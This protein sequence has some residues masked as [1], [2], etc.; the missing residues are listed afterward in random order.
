M[1]DPSNISVEELK[2]ALNRW[3]VPPQQ[4][5][6]CFEKADLVKLY[7]QNKELAEA[8]QAQRAKAANATSTSSS[9]ST[10]SVPSLPTMPNIG[11]SNLAFGGLLLLFTLQYLGIIGD[12]GMG[13][14][15][16]GGGD[17]EVSF[18]LADDSYALG[19]V[20]EVATLSEFNGALQLHKDG[21]GL[22]I[23]V[24]FFSHSCGPCKMIAPTFRKYAKEFKGRAVFLKVDVN[25]NRQT[26]AQ[27]QIR[28]MPT[29]QFYV[30]GKKVAEFSGADSR[31]LYSVTSD[32]AAKAEKKGTYV[33]KHVTEESLLAF[34]QA[35]D[36]SKVKDVPKVASK[37]GTKTAK[38]IRLLKKKYSAVPTLS[39]VQKESNEDDKDDKDD[40]NTQSTSTK[41]KKKKTANKK[42]QKNAKTSHSSSSLQSA[43]LEE[44]RQAIREKE[45]SEGEA[46]DDALDNA[47]LL[48]LSS[49]SNTLATK[50]N[51]AKVVVVGG[52]PAG[53]TAAIYSARAGLSPIVI[54]PSFGGQLLGK[55]V[56]VEN[57]PGVIGESAT[58]RGI[59]T[60]MRKQALSFDTIMVDDVAVT[61]DTSSTP[62]SIQVNGTSKRI[63]T[64]AII[65]ATGAD[66]RWLGVPGEYKYRGKGISSCA[67]CDGFLYRGTDVIVVG[68]GDTAMEDALVLARTSKTV[69]L[70]HRRGTFRASHVLQERVLNHKNI[71]IMWNTVVEQF[72]GNKK[73]GDVTHVD[74]K[75]TRPSD[76]QVSTRTLPI[77]A[78]FI[79][80]GHDPNT[81]FL[82]QT[83]GL[84]IDAHG[85]IV[86]AN[87]ESTKTSVEGIFASGDVAD[88]TYRQAVTSAGS[89]AMAALDAER[90]LSTKGLGV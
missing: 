28:A 42:H 6:A 35:H 83:K 67:T 86:K 49:K 80:I 1:G 41:A 76:G 88:A 20:A 79:A 38:L 36:E 87:L 73:T 14:M 82:K 31:R 24:D 60:M 90:W 63:F 54:A 68:G 85:Y 50:Q 3:R 23:V 10:S 27:C 62:Y 61:V 22:P 29:F 52:G 45:A 4:I 51:P 21:T 12:A 81:K 32:L 57:F 30:N 33:N 70:L 11:F 9:T 74:V 56:D 53:L 15:G 46:E 69:T 37:Y 17:D 39:D 5:E 43:S 16:G 26:S 7:K 75:T 8:R 59:V 65:V 66:S 64:H 77:G 48:T 44:L 55:G 18:N 25:R 40:Q 71:K 34:Y 19:K 78:A 84:D 47:F 72:T 13:G 58:G 89:G 2:R